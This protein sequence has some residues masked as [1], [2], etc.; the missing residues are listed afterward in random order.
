SSLLAA[1]LVPGAEYE[2]DFDALADGATDLE[3]GTE[4]VGNGNFTPSV[5]GGRLHFTANTNSNN[6]ALHI[7][8]I[9]GVAE[10][11]FTV[12]FDF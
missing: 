1:H 6:S 3:D 5:Q 2:Q 4:L 10:Q 11:G 12:T 7:D 8:S 9:P